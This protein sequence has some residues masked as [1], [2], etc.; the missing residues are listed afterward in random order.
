M[1]EEPSAIVKRNALRGQRQAGDS[2]RKVLGLPDARL[3]RLDQ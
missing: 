2:P 3:A 1:D